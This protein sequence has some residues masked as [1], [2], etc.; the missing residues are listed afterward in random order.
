MIADCKNIRRISADVYKAF[1]VFSLNSNVLRRDFHNML[2]ELRK[3]PD[4]CQGFDV[5][6]KYFK[7]FAKFGRYN[8][9]VAT[10][11]LGPFP[12]KSEAENM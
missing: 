3:I 8:L 5:R 12:K 7:N 10:R 1:A 9:D 4:D 6:S 11:D 2:P